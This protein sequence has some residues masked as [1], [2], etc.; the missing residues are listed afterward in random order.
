VIARVGN[1]WTGYVVDLHIPR[2]DGTGSVIQSDNPS[3]RGPDEDEALDTDERD[4]E[5]GDTGD[6]A[7]EHRTGEEQA[8]KN[9]E[10]DPV[11]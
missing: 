4:P 1:P 9:A 2:T 3:R 8:K 6:S 10:D 7:D 5:T 11:S